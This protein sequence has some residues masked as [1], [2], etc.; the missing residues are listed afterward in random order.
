MHK[1]IGL[2]PEEELLTS[3]A[4]SA[5]VMVLRSRVS[6]QQASVAT[7]SARSSM[8][9]KP[10]IMLNYISRRAASRYQLSCHQPRPACQARS[11]STP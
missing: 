1:G 8:H 6:R 11:S 2:W 5:F 9:L 10:P 3:K 7:C 4:A